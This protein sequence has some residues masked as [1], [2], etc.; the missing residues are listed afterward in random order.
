MMK[1]YKTK[2]MKRSTNVVTFVTF[3]NTIAS[4]IIRHNIEG[5]TIE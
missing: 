2:T 1:K 5:F 4:H 3:N